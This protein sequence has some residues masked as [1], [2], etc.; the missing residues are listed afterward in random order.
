MKRLLSASVLFTIIVCQLSAPAAA[1]EPGHRIVTKT[2]LQVLFGDLESQWL[3]AVQQKDAAALDVLL[4]EEFQ[5]WTPLPTSYPIPREDW[6]K[7]AF[8]RPFQSF[9]LTQMAVRGVT[10]D[11]SVA[12]FRLSQAFAA[13]QSQTEDFF[14][15]DVWLKS[16]KGDNWKCT[17]RYMW[18][19]SATAQPSGAKEDVKPTGKE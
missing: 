12:S 19:V 8:G 16:G 2:R 5:V 11:V 17:D 10:P 4:G 15:V 18:R 1:Q 6:Q 13:V 7:A 9:R 14:V 3:K